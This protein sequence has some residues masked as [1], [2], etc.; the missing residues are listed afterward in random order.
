M[1]KLPFCKYPKCIYICLWSS[2]KDI[3]DHFLAAYC[4]GNYQQNDSARVIRVKDGD[5]YV[6]E[7][8]YGLNRLKNVDA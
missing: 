4:E 8:K 7:K 3:I 6:L 2:F 5:T 1:S